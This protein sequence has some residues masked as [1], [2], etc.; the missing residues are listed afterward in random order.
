MSALP[1]L[2]S[3]PQIESIH[4]DHIVRAATFTG[5]TDFGWMTALNVPSSA[6]TFPY[7]G[8]GIG[9]AI[10]DSGIDDDDD[11][12]DVKGHNRIV[13]KESFVTGDK[14]TGDAFGHGNHVAG[15]VAGNGKHSTGTDFD[16]RIRGV[17]SN[18]NLIDLQRSGSQWGR[19]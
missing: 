13:Y 4:E 10:L 6:A 1:A 8:T 5:T 2:A 9:V 3:N 14:A 19:S 15:I 7:D 11:L 12:K 18:V 16:Y 17:A